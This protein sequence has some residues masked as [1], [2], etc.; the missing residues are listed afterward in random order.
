MRA[1]ARMWLTRCFDVIAA[2]AAVAVI[3]ALHWPWYVATLTPPD[4]DGY[5]HAPCGTATGI[6]AHPTLWAVTALAA[7]Q[8]AILLARHLAGGRRRVPGGDKGLMVLAAVFACFLVVA[9]ADLLPFSWVKILNLDGPVAQSP[10]MWPGVKDLT[11]V[12]VGNNGPDVLRMTWAYG[13]TTAVWAALTLLLAT[14][15]SPE[16]PRR[17]VGKNPDRRRSPAAGSFQEAAAD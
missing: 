9:D 5:V 4:C 11:Q 7:A 3:V 2:A 12:E 1:H 14:I 13:A 15:A 16:A 10:I 6:S 17:P 8:L